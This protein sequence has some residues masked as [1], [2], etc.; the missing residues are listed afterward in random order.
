MTEEEEIAEEIHDPQLTEDMLY[1]KFQTHINW[2]SETIRALLTWRG[3]YVT[4]N[5]FLNSLFRGRDL[6]ALNAMMLISYVEDPKG[7]RKLYRRQ[8]ASCNRHDSALVFSYCLLIQNSLL[9]TK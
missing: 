3:E 5:I 8:F 9:V 4:M 7:R 2:R 6:P 1:I